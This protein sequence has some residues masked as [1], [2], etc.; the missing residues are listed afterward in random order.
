MKILFGAKVKVVNFIIWPVKTQ[1]RFIQNSP[2]RIK[3]VRIF[4]LLMIQ[5]LVAR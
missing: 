2:L 5:L 1:I 3:M 4:A